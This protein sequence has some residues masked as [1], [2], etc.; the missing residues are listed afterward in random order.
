MNTIKTQ[1]TW[2][3]Y[4]LVFAVYLCIAIFAG[5]HHEPWADEAQSWL[6]ARDNHSLIDILRA[7]KYEGTLPTGHLINKAFQLAGF[8]YAHIFVI[9]APLILFMNVVLTEEYPDILITEHE[10]DKFENE[11]Y[12]KLVFVSHMIYKLDE[13][14]SETF[15][16]YVKKDLK[17]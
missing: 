12:E 9:F 1:K 10:K 11:D 4:G 15:Y 16:G 17:K 13:M 14:K 2:I 8:D 5:I 7:V 3:I 6:I